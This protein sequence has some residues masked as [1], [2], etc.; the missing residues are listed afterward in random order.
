MSLHLLGNANNG[1]VDAEADDSMTACLA[2][3]EEDS[4]VQSS[5]SLRMLA[6]HSNQSSPFIEYLHT[7]NVDLSLQ[8]S[9]EGPR[10]SCLGAFVV[11]K[12]AGRRKTTW[13]GTNRKSSSIAFRLG[14]PN[15]IGSS[16]LHKR[17]LQHQQLPVTRC[18]FWLLESPCSPGRQRQRQSQ[19]R[20]C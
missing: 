11:C 2:T 7:T 9:Q 12:N 14:N 10:C 3:G 5:P 19:Q 6:V 13:N 1:G 18:I 8:T 16:L 4:P 20:L 17:H 15:G